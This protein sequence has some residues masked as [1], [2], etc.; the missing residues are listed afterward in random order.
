MGASHIIISLIWS[1]KFSETIS[2]ILKSGSSAPLSYLDSLVSF[3]LAFRDA[4]AGRTSITL[5]GC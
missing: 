3:T 4:A 2:S 5:S 1:E